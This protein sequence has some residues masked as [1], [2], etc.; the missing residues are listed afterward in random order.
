MTGLYPSPERALT[1]IALAQIEQEI[2][3]LEAREVAFQK[4][5]QM[6]FEQFTATLCN[7]ATMEDEMAWEEWED[8]RLKLAIRQKSKEAILRYAASLG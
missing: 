3:Q 1:G 7:R 2:T 5:Y 4:K 6:T 8:L